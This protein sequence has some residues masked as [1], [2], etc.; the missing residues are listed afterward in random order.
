MRSAS[1]RFVLAYNG[2][3]YNFSEIKISL[4]KVGIAIFGLSDTA[5]LLAACEH[6]GIKKTLEHIV[7]MFAFALWDDYDK[8]LTLARDR[9]GEKPLYYGYQGK[10]FLFGSTLSPLRQHPSWIGCIDRQA[11]YQFVRY[12]YVPAPLSIYKG[13]R[14]LEPGSWMQLRWRDGRWCEQH[15]TY[16]SALSLAE[17][18][19]KSIYS[20]NF[21]SAVDE[22]ETRLE[23]VLRGQMKADV[24]LGAFLS[25]GVDSSA[26]VSLMQRAAGSPVKTFTIGFDEPAYDESISAEAVASYLGTEHTTVRLSD[27]DVL[28][29]IPKL[30]LIYDE[31]FADASQIPT[32][33]I[34]QI[35]RSEVTVALSGDGGD[36]IFGGYNRYLWGPRILSFS[37]LCS[38]PVRS[39]LANSMEMLSPST[40]DSLL[41]FISNSSAR[42]DTKVSN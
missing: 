24:P 21:S 16:W 34:S 6:W 5:V 12:N 3:I 26:V 30:A 15:E 38:R 11:L 35:A 42:C 41:A 27:M 9:F 1:G 29:L 22:L 2:E 14:K 32:T 33:L 20:G 19:R 28:E 10:D 39:A 25:G 40:W 4:E 13:V 18:S 8:C 36:E 31:P 23:A 17:S 37:K 7:G